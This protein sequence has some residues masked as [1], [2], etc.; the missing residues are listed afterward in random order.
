[1]QFPSFVSSQECLACQG[2]CRFRDVESPWRPRVS[3]QEVSAMCARVTQETQHPISPADFDAG[4]VRAREHNG[5]AQCVFLMMTRLTERS[6][7][8]SLS[9][10]TPPLCSGA[11]EEEGRTELI[12]SDHRCRIYANRP[13]EC[14][15][16]PF[17]F[18]KKEGRVWVGVHLSCP[19]VQE[20]RHTLFFTNYLLGLKIYFQSQRTVESLRSCLALGG[21]YTAYADE[22]EELFSLMST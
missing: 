5:Q 20:K 15:F 6:E 2:C 10:L 13:L 4:H 17:L 22:I 12:S 11:T 14:R 18:L 1:M 21:D 19:A 7:R 16:Y 9:E 3:T 8:K